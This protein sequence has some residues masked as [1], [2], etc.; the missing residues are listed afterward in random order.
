MNTRDVSIQRKLMKVVLFTSGVALLL[1][2]AS[3]IAYEFFTFRKTTLNQL[4]IEGKIIAANST[5]AI[6]FRSEGDA[7][8]TLS[9]L[10]AEKNIVAACLYDEKGNLFATYSTTSFKDKFPPVP[11]EEKY[12]IRGAYLEALF[13]CLKKITGLAHCIL[14]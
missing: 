12:T 7:T 13:P 2:S 5:A 10:K 11:Q 6:A 9:A 4:S 1:I 14:S 8:G 3:Y